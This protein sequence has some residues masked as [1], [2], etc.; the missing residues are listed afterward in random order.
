MLSG[1][2][3]ISQARYNSFLKSGDLISI[4]SGKSSQLHG[5]VFKK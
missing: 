4:K 2:Q 5:Q 1:N 3:S